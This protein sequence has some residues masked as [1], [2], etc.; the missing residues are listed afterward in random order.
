MSSLVSVTRT[1]RS[2]G[3][4][5]SAAAETPNFDRFREA[6]ADSTLSTHGRRVGLPEG[7][8]GYS[9]VGHLNIG[10][11]RVVKQDS[12]DVSDAVARSRGNNLPDEDD[13][14]PP[15]FQNEHILS[16]FDYAETNDGKVH[17]TGRGVL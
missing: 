4:T 1:D 8:M 13:Q 16:A 7:Q 10:S 14:D 15:I 17:F 5:P 3:E 9:E 12:A 11:G 6:G 2:S